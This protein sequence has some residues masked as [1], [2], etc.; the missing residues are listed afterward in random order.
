MKQFG[1]LDLFVVAVIVA[2][3]VFANLPIA[4]A[5]TAPSTGTFAYTVY[6]VGVNDILKGPIGF[7]GGAAAIVYG[8]VRA[9]Q[10]NVM[11]AAP[12]VLGGAVL[13]KA[14]TVVSSLGAIV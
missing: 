12:A 13:L 1:L 14:D 9:I 2:I 10:G 8:A 7:V 5:I 11:A 4:H 3:G 6:D